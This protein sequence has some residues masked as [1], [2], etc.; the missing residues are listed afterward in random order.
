[1]Q[2][3]FFT[4][5]KK[6][7]IIKVI[8]SIGAVIAKPEDTEK[9]IIKRVYNLLN[10]SKISGGNKVSIFWEKYYSKKIEKYY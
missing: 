2:S 5:E 7:L 3:S 6:K 8:M 10:F 1:M 9:P 4:L